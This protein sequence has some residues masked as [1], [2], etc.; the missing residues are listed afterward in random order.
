[1][2]HFGSYFS[3]RPFCSNGTKIDLHPA[4]LKA[5]T[6]PEDQKEKFAC[7]LQNT[8]PV[9]I[10]EAQAKRLC[11][12]PVLETFPYGLFKMELDR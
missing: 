4:L 12:S 9:I 3:E 11:R 2:G 10:G 1:M 8:S 7:A 5:M 6:R